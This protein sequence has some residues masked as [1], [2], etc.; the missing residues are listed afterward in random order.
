[1]IECSSPLT[2]DSH[3]LTL[4][5]RTCINSLGSRSPDPPACSGWHKSVA[6]WNT[7]IGAAR[8]LDETLR[9][10]T[11]SSA[12]LYMQLGAEDFAIWTTLLI[13]C[14]ITPSRVHCIVEVGLGMAFL[15][16]R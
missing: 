12:M 7:A 16:E 6:L 8:L 1:M 5:E 2:H 11:H 10:A 13:I 4:L 15:R 3:L 14:S 9:Y